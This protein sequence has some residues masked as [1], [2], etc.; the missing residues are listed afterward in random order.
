[1]ANESKKADARQ[2]EKGQSAN[3]SAH[4]PKGSRERVRGLLKAHEGAEAMD[5]LIDKLKSRFESHPERHEGVEWAKVEK[6][7][8]AYPEKLASLK[9]MEEAGGQPDVLKVEGN[10]IVFAD[11]SVFIPHQSEN[12]TARQA[13]EQAKALGAELMDKDLVEY[14]DNRL[15]RFGPGTMY[16][17][18]SNSGHYLTVDILTGGM[19]FP[20]EHFS[21]GWRGVLRVKK[22]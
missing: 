13:E 11:L 12:L 17:K 22:A 16:L 5:S 4:L 9:K 14:M 20:H 7:L 18:D 1:M 2:H 19:Y 8:S 21:R 6:S 15:G 10:D 3:E